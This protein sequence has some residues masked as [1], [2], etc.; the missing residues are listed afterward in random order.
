[1]KLLDIHVMKRWSQASDERDMVFAVS[2]IASKPKTW[3]HRS[4]TSGK[5]AALVYMRYVITALF[6][7]LVRPD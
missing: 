1:M 5:S 2:G 6:P 4:I 7:D 3:D